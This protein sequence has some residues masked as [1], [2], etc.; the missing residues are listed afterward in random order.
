M[1]RSSLNMFVYPR[2]VAF[3]ED[4]ATVPHS[5][6]YLIFLDE[7]GHDRFRVGDML[8]AVPGFHRVGSAYGVSILDT[9]GGKRGGMGFISTGSNINRAVVALDRPFNPSVSSEGWAAVVD[10]AT[11]SA[12]TFYMYPPGGTHDQEGIF[13]GTKC[14]RHKSRSRIGTTKSVPVSR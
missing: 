2:R 13:T 3:I 9:Q 8:P 7:Q 10:D 12:G 6:T 5:I 1:G 4:R 14:E 11:G